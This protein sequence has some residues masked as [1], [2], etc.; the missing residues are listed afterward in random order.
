MDQ[1]RPAEARRSHGG[2]KRICDEARFEMR[3]ICDE[4]LHLPGGVS[5][6]IGSAA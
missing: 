3:R 2:I 5:Y 1:R 6:L 4:A